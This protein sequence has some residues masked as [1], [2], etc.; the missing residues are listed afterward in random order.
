MRTPIILPETQ[1]CPICQRMPR[2]LIYSNITVIR[3]KPLF[4]NT[5]MRVSVCGEGNDKNTEK[6]IARWNEKVQSATEKQKG[7]CHYE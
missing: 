7:R 3:C 4:Q 5:H 2:V 1:K 6:A